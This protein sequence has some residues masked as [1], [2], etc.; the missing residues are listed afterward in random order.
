MKVAQ[1]EEWTIL[2]IDLSIQA[3]GITDLEGM[4]EWGGNSFLHLEWMIREVFVHT[5]VHGIPVYGKG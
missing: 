1:F 2:E 5:T 4:E 3:L